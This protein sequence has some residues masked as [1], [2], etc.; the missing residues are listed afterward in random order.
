MVDFFTPFFFIIL[1]SVLMIVLLPTQ[2]KWA[3][4][5]K[6]IDK[7][8]H[9]KIH[10]TNTPTSGGLSIYLALC[11]LFIYLSSQDKTYFGIF[12]SITILLILGTWD[13]IS[14][15]NAK[16]K[17]FIQSIAC[18]IT[19]FFGTEIN[20]LSNP[21]GPAIHINSFGKIL[22]FCWLLGIINA[23]NL[24]DG[25]D[26]LASGISSIACIAMAIIGFK[27]NHSMPFILSLCLGVCCFFFYR[28][29]RHPAQIFLGD[30]G[31]TL[32]GFILACIS[33]NG[34]LK[35][36]LSL[37]FFSPL[38]ILC[39]P[40]SDT[41]WT[42]IRRLIKKQKIFNADKDHIHHTLLNKGLNASL[43]TLILC[44]FSAA[45]SGLAIMIHLPPHLLPYTSLIYVLMCIYQI[46]FIVIKIK[47]HHSKTKYQLNE[48]SQG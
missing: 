38:L 48:H 27:L 22:S 9:R 31:S 19:I 30:S 11:P 23:M 18:L 2:K 16:I 7:P 46:N 37:S 4:F 21:F 34:V 6:L 1:T 40:L 10:S 8:C 25:I 13:D 33:I 15:I 20:W 36:T 39:I 47:Q 44:S 24:I 32:I 41:T 12:I 26:G 35:S 42:I 5:F 28:Y 14:P 45:T 3:K 29:N 17:L 43:I